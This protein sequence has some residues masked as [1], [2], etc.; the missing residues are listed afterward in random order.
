[1]RSGVFLGVPPT[2]AVMNCS[3]GI[4]DGF[5][6]DPSTDFDLPFLLFSVISGSLKL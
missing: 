3:V 4:E 2:A 5:G 6:T 1:M